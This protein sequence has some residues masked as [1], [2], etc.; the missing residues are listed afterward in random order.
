MTLWNDACRALF[1]VFFSIPILVKKNGN[2]K[3]KEC[4]SNDSTVF[5]SVLLC[6]CKELHIVYNCY[7]FEL[8][9]YCVVL[10]DLVS[11]S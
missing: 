6:L 2:Y 7:Q 9:H 5:I 1:F 11:F 10:S 4:L 3:R 8:G